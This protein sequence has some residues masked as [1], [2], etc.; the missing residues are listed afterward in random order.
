MPSAEGQI[1]A[2][3]LGVGQGIVFLDEAARAAHHVE[4]HEVAPIVGVFALFKGGERA[5]RTLVTH[6][7]GAFA[8]GTEQFFGANTEV[9]GGVFGEEEA[10]LGGEVEIGFVVGRGREEDALA[11][12]LL[13]IFFDGLV[14]SSFAVAQ[15]V[16]FVDNDDAETAQVWQ[17]VDGRC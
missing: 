4:A 11:L 16:A 6:V 14:A 8:D 10:Q 9:F 2:A 15:V 13:D 17:F 5:H 3:R 7:E 12:V 1:F